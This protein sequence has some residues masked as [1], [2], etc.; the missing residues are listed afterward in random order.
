MI[1][2]GL[3][4][5]TKD[6]GKGT[7]KSSFFKLE[8]KKD[9]K[10][11]L[12]QCQIKDFKGQNKRE[13]A[14]RLLQYVRDN[15][16]TSHFFIWFV[17]CWCIYTYLYYYYL[18]K[19]SPAKRLIPQ[20]NATWVESNA[21]Q[22]KTAQPSTPRAQKQDACK[23][24]AINFWDIVIYYIKDTHAILTFF[25]KICFISRCRWRFFS[26]HLSIAL[27]CV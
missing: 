7:R 10:P 14:N 9:I 25:D 17:L 27:I 24:S 2:I 21:A 12:I 26:L 18:E 16:T 13:A 19:Q 11:M 3:F 4:D 20:V 8:F 22:T 23:P 5:K 6:L 15:C 1:D